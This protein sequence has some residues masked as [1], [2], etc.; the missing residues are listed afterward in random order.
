MKSSSAKPAQNFTE[1]KKALSPA[2]GISPYG[3]QTAAAPQLV[4]ARLQHRF[5]VRASNQPLSQLDTRLITDLW[6]HTSAA[7][8]PSSPLRGRQKL[9]A[10]AYNPLTKGKERGKNSEKAQPLA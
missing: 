5:R 8:R 9:P 1:Q 6:G 2:H 7:T 4:K 10:Q 3:F